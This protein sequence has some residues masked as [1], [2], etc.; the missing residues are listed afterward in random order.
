MSKMYKTRHLDEEVMTRNG[1]QMTVGTGRK[2]CRKLKGKEGHGKKINTG[3]TRVFSYV[4]GDWS[5]RVQERNLVKDLGLQGTD[6]LVQ[7]Q[8]KSTEL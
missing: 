7:E 6:T 3:H 4:A 5:L 1:C 8:I 2:L